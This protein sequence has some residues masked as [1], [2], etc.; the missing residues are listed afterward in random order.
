MAPESSSCALLSALF[1]EELLPEVGDDFDE[2]D[3][4]DDFDDED[5]D[6]EVLLSL[7]SLS[8]LSSLL[9]LSSV[10]A[11]PLSAALPRQSS[12]SESLMVSSEL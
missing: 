3:E 8:S 10:L 11:G 7:S 2:E 1:D 12:S 6:D 9:S 5:D 4:D